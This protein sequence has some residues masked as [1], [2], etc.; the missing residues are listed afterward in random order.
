MV[1]EEEA[2]VWCA[3]IIWFFSWFVLIYKGFVLE[4]GVSFGL[5]FEI[6]CGQCQMSMCGYVCTWAVVCGVELS[7]GD[8]S[9]T[10]N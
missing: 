6:L 2:M 10:K 5:R 7:E 1:L 8:R 3:Y 4:V 9:Y